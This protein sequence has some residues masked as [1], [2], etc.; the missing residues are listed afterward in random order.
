M[1]GKRKRFDADMHKKAQK[2]KANERICRMFFFE[3]SYRTQNGGQYNFILFCKLSNFKRESVGESRR[4]VTTFGS[5]SRFFWLEKSLLR[6][7]RRIL[8]PRLAF[9]PSHEGNENPPAAARRITLYYFIDF[10]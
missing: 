1:K 7:K 3:I 9:L 2:P 4:N 8:S 5:C 10:V 6:K